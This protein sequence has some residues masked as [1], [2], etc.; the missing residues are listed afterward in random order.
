MLSILGLGWRYV[1]IGIVRALSAETLTTLEY[2]LAEQ[3]SD[4]LEDRS[5]DA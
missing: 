1:A 2:F 5:S 4:K 3:P